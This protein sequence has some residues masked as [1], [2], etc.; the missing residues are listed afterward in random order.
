MPLFPDLFEQVEKLLRDDLT[1]A[2]AAE[3]IKRYEQTR[4]RSVGLPSEDWELD[5]PRKLTPTQEKLVGFLRARD[6]NQASI[7]DAMR[8][9]NKQPASEKER[10]SF[11]ASIRRTNDRFTDHQV[12]L[13]IHLD[14]KANAIRLTR[15]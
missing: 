2:N 8:T 12:N 13:H 3:H 9:M 5:V 10:K 7:S 6:G 1:P 4:R 11:L 14:R 15:I